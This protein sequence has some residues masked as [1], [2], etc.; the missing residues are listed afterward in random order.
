MTRTTHPT[1]A[2]DIILRLPVVAAYILSSQQQGDNNNQQTT[3][4]TTT[5]DLCIK[6]PKGKS[7]QQRV[8]NKVIE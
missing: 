5:N 6:T 1:H 3:T 8:E 2:R 4:T 7:S